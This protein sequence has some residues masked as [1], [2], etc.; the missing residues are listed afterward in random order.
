M[1]SRLDSIACDTETCTSRSHVWRSIWMERSRNAKSTIPSAETL[2]SCL[3]LPQDVKISH[4]CSHRLG[5]GY[6]SGQLST[7][8]CYPPER[9]HT[10]AQPYTVQVSRQRIAKLVPAVHS[11][12]S[13]FRQ[14][15]YLCEHVRPSR[16][17]NINLCRW[18]DQFVP[19]AQSPKVS[20][21]GRPNDSLTG[22]RTRITRA[23]LSIKV[24]KKI[25]RRPSWVILTV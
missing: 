12:S 17:Q 11:G 7:S 6:M 16:Q 10:S 15:L 14:P 19:E 25:I 13:E 23:S 1:Q 18:F 3:K 20:F 5:P 22:P 9:G 4:F 8:D 21:R 24:S 2:A